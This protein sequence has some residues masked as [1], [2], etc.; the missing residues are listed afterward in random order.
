MSKPLS[1]GDRVRLVA[2]PAFVK[3][4]DPM[5]ALR[6]PNVLAIGTEGTVINQR[7]GGYWSIHFANGTFLLEP[8]YLEAIEP[9]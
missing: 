1:A 5:P 3:T 6:S 7:P 8:Q 9:G 2:L 4:A